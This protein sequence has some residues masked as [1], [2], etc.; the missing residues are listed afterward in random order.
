MNYYVKKQKIKELFQ[1][2]TYYFLN[3]ALTLSIK[4]FSLSL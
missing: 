4:A 2:L 3:F 1:L